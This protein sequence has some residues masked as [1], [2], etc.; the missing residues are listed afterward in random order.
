MSKKVK[1]LFELFRPEHYELELALDAQ[2][3]R[4]SGTVV[5]AGYKSGRPSQRLTL[6]Q[7]GLTITAAT[8][9]H[10]DKKDDRQIVVD[11]INNHK[12]YDE[13]R[14]H[15][16]AKLYPGKYTVSLNFE[17]RITK[18]MTGL[19]PCFFKHANKDKVLLATQFQSHHAREVFPCIDEPEAKAT[20]G[21]TL[22]TPEGETVLSN[23]PMKSQESRAKS[24]E[25]RKN[26]SQLAAVSSQLVTTFERT[27]RMSTYLLAFA[28]GDMHGVEAKT[29]SGTV[30]K[31]WASA[32]QPK[33]MLEYANKEAVRLLDFFTDY[34]GI[35]FPLPKCDQLALPD[36]ESGA[37]E[38]WGLITYREIALLT[39]PDN[40]SL[41]SE[42]YISMVVAHELSHQWFGNLVTMRWWDDLWLN[43]SFASLMEHIALDA[44]HPDWNQWESYTIS[45]V[46]STS[47]RDIY[48]DVQPVGVDVDDPDAISALFDPAIVYAKGGRLL[49]MLREHIGDEAY[50]AGLKQYFTKHAYQNT[51]REDLWQALSHASQQDIPAL[52]TP[53]LTQAGMPLI[54]ITNK[55]D[56]LHI[57]QSRFIMDSEGDASLWP[58]PLLANQPLSADIL[59]AATGAL[60]APKSLP[61]IL[62]Q[63]ASGHYVVKYADTASLDS[64]A[65]AIS[66]QTIPA[67][68]RVNVLN[69]LLLLA[70][71]GD[72]SI[73]DVLKV[74]E[75]CQSEPREAV[76]S[77][78]AR[79]IGLSS[80]LG[81]GIEPLETA[82][83][84]L[85]CKLAADWHKKLGWDEKNGDT[86]NDIALRSITL[87]LL[88]IGED[89]KTVDEA[90]KRFA[91]AK[92]IEDLP[93]ELRGLLLQTVGRRATQKQID[94]L[95][96]AYKTTAN[97]DIQMAICSGV[98][99]T[100]DPAIA[101][102]IIEVAL[103]NDGFV[104]P[105]D[106]LRWY[107]L[108]MRN[109]HT[110]HLAWEWI[111]GEWDRIY[112]QLGGAKA[113]DYIPSYS[114][115][116]M[117]T[118]EWLDEYEV[119]FTPLLKNVA[120]R[121]NIKVGMAEIKARIAWRD[122]DLPAL[123]AHLTVQ[124]K[125]R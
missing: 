4:F 74:V 9:T 112:E 41:S 71:R 97:P 27:P 91:R 18:P 67:E 53:W 62:N 109:R 34:F 121:R 13:L 28:V 68:T 61:L 111:T 32:A 45:D 101:R 58:V 7:K 79:A 116:A 83:K 56:T 66:K 20:F 21:L 1:R 81:E 59:H 117:N 37:M 64:I 6:H 26:D 30:V 84:K 93:A 99:D 125:T 44:L 65:T 25:Q 2:K 114:A 51:T 55:K 46:I 50:R 86:P 70:R 52:M 88:L 11:R 36:F 105:Q 69:D 108:L 96:A 16:S 87:G 48:K 98:T 38:N 82:L 75:K 60:D 33:K 94:T 92:S 42:Q 110:R 120:L 102:H 104:R 72:G 122:R 54:T 103:S 76:W 80:G 85:R 73:V 119:F 17:G 124:A 43:E 24:P 22:L 123:K 89:K 12:A 8:I 39:D 57:T 5:I 118:K 95:L 100:K 31:T 77:M 29:S 23:T 115:N 3:M 63:H 14:L 90:L 10:H 40:R 107:A 35:P 49:K 78:M 15:S 19:Y 113:L 106:M 47:N